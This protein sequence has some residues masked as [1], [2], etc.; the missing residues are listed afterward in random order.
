MKPRPFDYFAPHTL[1]E[2]L[3]LLAEYG[4]RARPLAGGQSLI[5]QMNQREI[6]PQVIVDLNR[7]PELDYV[8]R[9]ADGVLAIGAMT[10]QQHLVSDEEIFRANPALVAAANSV[11]FPAIRSRGTL[12]GSVANAEP[13][14]QI[15]LMLTV[16]DAQATI[17]RQGGRRT[18]PISAL[19]IGPRATT[20]EPDELLVELAIP[21]LDPSAGYA[22]TEFRRGH[23]GPPLISI[24]AVIV[25]DSD[26]AIESARL[27]ASG[28]QS[29]PLRL[30]DEEALLQGQMPLLGNFGEVAENAAKRVESGDQVL[31]DVALRQRVMRA[32]LKRALVEGTSLAMQREEKVQ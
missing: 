19:F 12:G 25:L 9:V 26:G 5:Q 7:V 3:A 15:P 32:L 27:G 2:A 20:I 30:S 22:V 16:L 10:R 21:S 4:S 13:G 8:R 11:A 31:A 24:A 29:I 1:D 28:V 17:V 18:T 14:A 6:S 23:S